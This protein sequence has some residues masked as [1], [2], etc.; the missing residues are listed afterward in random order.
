MW[1]IRVF[2]TISLMA[3]IYSIVNQS[4]F[5]ILSAFLFH[6]IISI[7][8]NAICYHRYLSHRSFETGRNRK[9]FLLLTNLL[10]GQG[11]ILYA[12]A[13]HRRHHKHSD[14]DLDP[15]NSKDGYFKNFF[16]TLNN[17]D[18]FVRKRISLPLDLVKDPIVLFF[19]KNYNS[20]WM[21]I[22]LVSLIV[23]Y[24][25]CLFLLTSV[26]LTTLHTNLVRTFLSH[27]KGK[28][29]YRNYDTPD[30]STNTRLQWLSLSESL[31]NNHHKYPTLYNHAILSNEFDHAGWI[32]RNFFE[33]VDNK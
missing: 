21:S 12:V 17:F 1:S 29:F 24:R 3:L 28:F 8:G 13:I 11:S 7:F 5:W 27:G 2:W 31:H 20:I 18:Y 10:T 15:H 22:I 19:H 4:F 30:F 6:Y 16:F 33:V 26:G 32:V 14:T 9:I 25:I 23:D